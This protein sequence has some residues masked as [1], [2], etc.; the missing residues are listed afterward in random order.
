[1]SLDGNSILASL[2]IGLI[3]AALFIYG[4][5]Q[6]RLPYMLAG[7]VMAIYP[8]FITNVP[9]MFAVAVGVI[10]VLWGA[11]KFGA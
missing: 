2:F 8:Y 5:K 9:A 4:R 6:G 7:V 1:M 10:A 11:V 3:G